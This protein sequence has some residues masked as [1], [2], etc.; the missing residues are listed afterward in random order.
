MNAKYIAAM[1]L[2]MLGIVVLAY[3]GITSTILG[4]PMDYLGLH[5]ETTHN[6]AF[7]PIVGVLPLIGGIIVLVAKSTR[8]QIPGSPRVTK[9]KLAVNS[10]IPKRF[11][12]LVLTTS[13]EYLNDGKSRGDSAA[14][15]FAQEMY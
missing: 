13:A 8:V 1:M 2:I 6:H 15:Q 3:S 9:P 4:Q 12:R 11:R 10:G 14:A 7:P 5:E